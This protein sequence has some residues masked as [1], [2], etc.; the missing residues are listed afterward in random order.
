MTTNVVR[1]DRRRML[2]G[3][4]ATAAALAAAS[5]LIDATAAPSVADAIPSTGRESL[6]ALLLQFPPEEAHRLRIEILAI[7]AAVKKMCARGDDFQTIR[8]FVRT[9]CQQNHMDWKRE[10]GI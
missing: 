6:D 4:G 3:M 8:N 5:T 2:L 9:Q 10:R 1:I 7:L